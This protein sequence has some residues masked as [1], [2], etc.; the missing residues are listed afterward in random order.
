MT[1]PT[2]DS[3]PSEPRVRFVDHAGMRVILLDFSGATPADG[4]GRIAEARAFVARLQP[5]G[6]HYTLT[7]VRRTHYNKEIIEAIKELTA[8][9]RPFVRAAAVVSDQ[10]L[11]RATISMIALVSRRKLATFDSREAALEHLAKEH[12]AATGGAKG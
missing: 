8:H 2:V 1:N 4:L 6:S 12:A 10:A 7:D 9:N 5:D 3:A 11:H